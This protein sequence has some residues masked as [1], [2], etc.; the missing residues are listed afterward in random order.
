[1]RD[2]QWYAQAIEILTT[3]PSWVVAGQQLGLSAG[4]AKQLA[5][6]LRS[7]GEAIPHKGRGGR[8]SVASVL[9]RLV[10]VDSC[11]DPALTLAGERGTLESCAS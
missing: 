10:E 6:R 3:A 7:A 9:A 8:P 5:I 11:V 1:M 4:A 2:A